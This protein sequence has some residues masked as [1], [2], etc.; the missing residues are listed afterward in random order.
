MLLEEAIRKALAEV[1]ADLTIDSTGSAW[2]A[3]R[4]Y[5]R[6]LQVSRSIPVVEGGQSDFLLDFWM[7]GVV[8]GTGIVAGFNDVVASIVAFLIERAAIRTMASR[9]I[10]FEP[11]SSGEAHERGA[12]EFVS[13]MWS[14]LERRVTGQD[15]LEPL[16]ASLN[17]VLI[18]REAANRPELRQLRPFTSHFSLCFSRT[19]G[20]P[21][22]R[23]C[24][25]AYP[26][27][28]GLYRVTSA[29]GSV[30]IDGVDAIQ[31]VDALVAD[32]PPNCGPA[33]HGTAEDT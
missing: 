18:V 15:L 32:L 20:Y 30:V 12:A 23:D 7:Q 4:R 25:H 8:Y 19:T 33:I 22:S 2:A 21:F 13:Q 27:G 1:P 24:P 9:F 17:L 6:S 14:D 29:D 3:V 28:S 10:W 16:R 26:I 31:T 11:R 5:P